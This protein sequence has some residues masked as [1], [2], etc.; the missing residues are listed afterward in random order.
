MIFWSRNYSSQL[1]FLTS[2]KQSTDKTI[3]RL[4]ANPHWTQSNI[5]CLFFNNIHILFPGREPNTALLEV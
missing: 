1:Y 2:Y 3:G 4:K 5:S